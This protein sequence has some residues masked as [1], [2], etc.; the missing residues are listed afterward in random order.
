MTHGGSGALSRPFQALPD[1]G[2][3]QVAAALAE[4]PAGI[5]M[6]D[7]RRLVPVMAALPGQLNFLTAESVAAAVILKATIA[8]TTRSD[9]LDR[10]ARAVGVQVE[11][12]GT[13][14]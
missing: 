13:T 12:V 8:V 9:L 14:G 6:L 10:T 1:D 5:G 11:V 4:L 2:R 3:Q 7:A